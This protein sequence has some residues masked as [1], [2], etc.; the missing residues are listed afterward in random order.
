MLPTFGGGGT[1][2]SFFSCFLWFP[3]TYFWFTVISIIIVERKIKLKQIGTA[4]WY[5]D[6]Q[7]RCLAQ[8]LPRK[9]HYWCFYFSCYLHSAQW[10]STACPPSWRRWS[11]GTRSRAWSGSSPSTS[12]ASRT[13]RAGPSSATSL[14]RSSFQVGLCRYLYKSSRSGNRFLLLGGWIRCFFDPWVRIRERLF[15]DPGFW[16]PDPEPIFPRA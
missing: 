5:F 13:A 15:P 8:W 1:E 11:P 7:Y 4:L 14:S 16:V 12:P 9:I 2:R 6:W 3:K 10:R